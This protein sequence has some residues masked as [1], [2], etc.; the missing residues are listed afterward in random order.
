MTLPVTFLPV[1][2]LLIFIILFFIIVLVLQLHG[3]MIVRENNLLVFHFPSEANPLRLELDITIKDSYLLDGIL[4]GELS[5]SNKLTTKRR[6][7][8]D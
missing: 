2:L 5:P 1:I 3:L 4:E 7:L 6:Y 8:L